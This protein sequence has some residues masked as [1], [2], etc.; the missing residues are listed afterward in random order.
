MAVSAPQLV[1]L[2]S[3]QAGAGTPGTPYGPVSFSAQ[4]VA[5]L[6]RYW[7]AELTVLAG[8]LT[9]RRGQYWILSLT[10]TQPCCRKC[11]GG[12]LYPLCPTKHPQ[13][14]LTL[15]VLAG[16]EPS[17]F[18]WG[19]SSSDSE[20]PRVPGLGRAT[21]LKWDDGLLFPPLSGYAS[22]LLLPAPVPRV[23][24]PTS[25]GTFSSG[26]GKRRV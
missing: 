1:P 24:A 15:Q 12:W 7:G 26:T 4:L 3:Q 6:P 21:A 17:P 20:K 11:R 10:L 9:P 5:P 19:H 18:L 22:S 8:G 14:F 16:M 25:Q 23:P 2:L 13:A